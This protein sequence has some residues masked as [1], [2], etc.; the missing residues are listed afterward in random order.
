[1]AEKHVLKFKAN[2]NCKSCVKNQIRGF[3][4]VCSIQDN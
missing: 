1:M 4:R 3:D 2:I